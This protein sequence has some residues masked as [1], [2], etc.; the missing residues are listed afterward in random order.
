MEMDNEK[1]NGDN[2]DTNVTNDVEELHRLQRESSAMVKLLKTLEKEEHALQCELEILAREALLCGF[3]PAVV[4]PASSKRRR[5][6]A[7]G[8]TKKE[9]Q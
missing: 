3:D 7:G 5:T 6:P 9:T 4:E 8:R 1:G 2:A